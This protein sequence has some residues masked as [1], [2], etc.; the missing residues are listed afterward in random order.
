MPLS[1]FRS[2]GLGDMTTTNMSLQLSDH[3]I[4]KPHGVIEDVLVKVDKFIFP[5]DFVLL[6]FEEDRSCPLILGRPFLNTGKAIIDVHESKLTFRV[7][8]EKVDF[9][10]SKLMKYPLD[11]E[12]CMKICV[13][14]DCV[15]EVNSVS[16]V[17][18]GDEIPSDELE[19]ME[20]HEHEFVKPELLVRSPF[21]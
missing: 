20:G 11:D 5:V 12:S 17:S 14:D 9:V 13:I 8:D 18:G 1:I 3:S 6:D 10:M 4:K 21:Y 19:S 2:L 15:Q 7:G 16:Y